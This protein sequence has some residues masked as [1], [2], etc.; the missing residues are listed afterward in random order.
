[1]KGEDGEVQSPEER[2]TVKELLGILLSVETR[3]GGAGSASMAGYAR[4]SVRIQVY[5]L[6]SLIEG[7]KAWGRL[8]ARYC[9]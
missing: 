7:P 6:L 9:K 2:R 4:S 3:P 5:S 8:E 1:M